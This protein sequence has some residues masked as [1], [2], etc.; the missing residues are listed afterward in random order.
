MRYKIKFSYDGTNFYG[1]Q[2]QPGLRTVEEELEKALYS[3]NNHQETKVIGSGRTDKGVHALSQVAHF[4]LSVTITLYKLKCALN[5][6]LPEDIHV[7][8]TE[9]VDNNFHARFSAKKKKY[10]YV[11]NLGE[12]NPLERNIIFQYGKKINLDIALMKE[13]IK[14][15]LGKHNFYNFVSKFLFYILLDLK[16]LYH[17]V[18]DILMYIPFHH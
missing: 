6:L 11:L 9:L 2:K 1:Y 16:F 10:R 7:F 17:L 14:S 15:F 4:D 5:S 18:Y 8:S 3:I 12:Y 13:E